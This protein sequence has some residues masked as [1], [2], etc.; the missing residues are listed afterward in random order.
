MKDF[1]FHPALDAGF[2]YVVCI[3]SLCKFIVFQGSKFSSQIVVTNDLF[4]LY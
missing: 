3:T 2:V 1:Y 4:P